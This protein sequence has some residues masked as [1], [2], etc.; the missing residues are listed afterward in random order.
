MDLGCSA[1]VSH[2]DQALSERKVKLIK[3]Q[4]DTQIV[5]QNARA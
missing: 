4:M 5:I 2:L 1:V 3:S